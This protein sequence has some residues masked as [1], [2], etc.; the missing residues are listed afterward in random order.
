MNESCSRY[1]CTSQVPIECRE[2]ARAL[3]EIVSVDDAKGN[4]FLDETNR[5][6]QR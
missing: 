3:M 2:A 6:N 4:L 5:R 1:T